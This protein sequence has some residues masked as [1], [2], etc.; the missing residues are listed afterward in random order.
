MRLKGKL[1]IFNYK[2]TWSLDS[3]LSPIICEGLKKFLEVVTSEDTCAG[4]P[5]IIFNENNL[6]SESEEDFDKALEIWHNELRKMIFA[7]D[8]DA[9]K[10]DI[11]GYDFEIRFVDLGKTEKGFTRTRTEI[12]SQDEYDRYNKDIEDYE[13]KRRE[14]LELTFKRWN[15]LW[16]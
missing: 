9:E 4:C 13:E 8:E 12:D 11:G 15:N 7:F 5:H 6:N 3:T 1:P 10:P 16:W 14:G 2:D